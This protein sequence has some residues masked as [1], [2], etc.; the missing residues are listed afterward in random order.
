MNLC[1]SIHRSLLSRRSSLSCTRWMLIHWFGWMLCR[2]NAFM[3]WHHRLY[4]SAQRVLKPPKAVPMR[5]CWA[6]S[7]SACTACWKLTSFLHTYHCHQMEKEMLHVL[8]V[9]W[10]FLWV[11]SKRIWYRRWSLGP[12]RSVPVT[13][14]FRLQQALPTTVLPLPPLQQAQKCTLRNHACS[15]R[16]NANAMVSPRHNRTAH[17]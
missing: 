6:L 17:N 8:K 12:E 2:M 10:C 13:E 14:V 15:E 16:R 7:T 4:R 11:R 3:P 1:C 9:H 5:L